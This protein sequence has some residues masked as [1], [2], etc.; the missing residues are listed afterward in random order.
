MSTCW[1]GAAAPTP[2]ACRQ[3]LMKAL[4]V[5]SWRLLVEQR[6]NTHPSVCVGVNHIGSLALLFQMAPIIALFHLQMFYGA[7][8]LHSQLR[9]E[10]LM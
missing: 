5:P 6:S 1:C 3:P 7:V 8:L 2:L 9:F 4:Q 10:Q